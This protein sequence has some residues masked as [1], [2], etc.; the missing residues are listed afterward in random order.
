[1]CTTTWQQEVTSYPVR[2]SWIWNLE[3]WIVFVWRPSSNRS[4]PDNFVSGQ[5]GEGN[6]WEKG[7]YTENTELVDS[8]LDVVRKEATCPTLSGQRDFIYLLPDFET[9]LPYFCRFDRSPFRFDDWCLVVL[10]IPGLLNS[11]LKK[12]PV[13]LIPFPLL[14]FFMTG[15]TPLTSRGS[16]QYRALSVPELTQQMFV[17]KNMMC[18]ADPRHGCYFTASTLF[19]GRM[20][21]KR[22][23][24]PDVVSTEQEFVILCGVDLEQHQGSLRRN[25]KTGLLCRRGGVDSHGAPRVDLTGCDA[26]NGTPLFLA[27]HVV[28]FKWLFPWGPS[29]VVAGAWILGFIIRR[30]QTSLAAAR[31]SLRATTGAVSREK[32]LSRKHTDA[33]RHTHWTSS[34][35]S[36]TTWLSASSTTLQVPLPTSSRHRTR[37]WMT[38]HSTSCSPR[39]TENKPITA[40]QKACQSVIRRRLSCSIEQGNLREKEVSINQLVLVP[41]ETRTVLTATFLKTPKLRKWSIEQGNLWEKIVPMHRLGPYLMNRDRW[42]SQNIARKLVITNSKQLM[43]KKNAEFSEKNYGDSKWIFVKFI[44]KVLQ[45]WRNCENSKVLHSIRSQDESSSRTWTL[46]WNYQAE[47]KNYKNEV[48]CMSDPKDFQD[49]ESVR[50]GNSHVT[51]RPVSF[52]P[53]F[54]R[55]A[56]LQRKAAKHLGHTW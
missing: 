35:M 30:P 52:P 32:R 13:N 38:W 24:W 42:L 25:V 26:G 46:F 55:I 34:V 14:H 39:H 17:P 21:K 20:S 2:F 49:A 45:R 15:F 10:P 4:R 7:H 56:E 27:V 3:P 18:A 53:P 28:Y 22:G 16:Q 19:R 11:V 44:N 12:L 31:P 50:S 5:T 48:N 9:N 8:V 37:T 47:Y 51:S 54:F 40:I 33:P 41:Q 1:M 6:N 23:L 36:P 43:P 29:V